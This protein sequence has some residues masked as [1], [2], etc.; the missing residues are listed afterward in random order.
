MTNIAL[1]MPAFRPPPVFPDV[2]KGI[3]ALDTDGRI[4]SIVI[5]DDGSEAATRRCSRG[6]AIPRVTIVRRDLNGGQGAALKTGIACALKHVPDLVGVITADADG[7]H[8]PR[9]VVT[10]AHAF[11]QQPDAVVLGVRAFGRD[12]PLRSR[13]GNILTT[14]LVSWLGGLSVADT[15]TGLRGW[16]RRACERNLHNPATGFEFNLSTLLPPRRPA[17][18]SSSDRFRRSTSAEIPPVTSVRSRIRSGSTASREARNASSHRRIGRVSRIV[19]SRVIRL[20]ALRGHI[21]DRKVRARLVA[22]NNRVVL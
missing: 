13:I 6:G 8:A 18:R 9:D 20:M 1:V 11:A 19:Q 21:Y 7:Q 12:V 17:M 2:V 10:I 5:V 15:Q 4:H 3:T 16:P 14:R 22:S